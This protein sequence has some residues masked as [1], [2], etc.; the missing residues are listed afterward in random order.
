MFWCERLREGET[1]CICESGWLDI[2]FTDVIFYNDT[3]KLMLQP[4]YGSECV[5]FHIRNGE[6]VSPI[7]S[8]KLQFQSMQHVRF[9]LL[10]GELTLIGTITPHSNA[11]KRKEGEYPSLCPFGEAELL[12]EPQKLKKKK[13]SHRIEIETVERVHDTSFQSNVF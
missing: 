4:E 11:V 9:K 6:T 7:L 12:N 10:G 8:F 1:F 3:L 2:K 13:D 5:L